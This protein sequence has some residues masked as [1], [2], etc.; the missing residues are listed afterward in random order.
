VAYGIKDEFRSQGTSSLV[1]NGLW[2]SDT[3]VAGQ[4]LAIR[5]QNIGTDPSAFEVLI[6]GREI[7]IQSISDTAILIQA[8]QYFLDGWDVELRSSFSGEVFSL[9]YPHVPNPIITSVS[10]REFA[11]GDTI[12]IRGKY[13][14]PI[15]AWNETTIFINPDM[16]R[17]S[18]SEDEIKFYVRGSSPPPGSAFGVLVE[19]GHAKSEAFSFRYAPI[20]VYDFFPKEGRPGDTITVVGKNF[21][22]APGLNFTS[23]E[24]FNFGWRNIRQSYDTL[25]LM[26]TEMAV[27]PEELPLNRRLRV[28]S[29]GA[30]TAFSQDV[31]TY[32]E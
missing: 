5:G 19:V 13:F 17:T 15:P 18:G 12:T 24:G 29:N 20:E 23:L 9:N 25:T 31:F 4:T 2:P 27:R 28:S 21:H 14:S 10:P 6:Q 26:V 22:G 3:I 11:D 32:R 30:G 7:P 8:P 16:T 1:I